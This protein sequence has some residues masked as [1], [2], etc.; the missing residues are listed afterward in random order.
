[1]KY[2]DVR[3]K[4]KKYRAI[5]LSSSL[6]QLGS[7][8]AA[9]GATAIINKIGMKYACNYSKYELE[10]LPVSNVIGGKMR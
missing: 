5:Q 1:M 7:D 3:F 2:V 4:G 6:Y 9:F 8:T 10:I